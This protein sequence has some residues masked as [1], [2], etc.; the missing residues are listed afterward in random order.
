MRLS[1]FIE[2][3][4]VKR[5]KP[6]RTKP[7]VAAHKS[8]V[9]ILTVWGAAL[10]GLVVMVL[11]QDA[12]DRSG[13]VSGLSS[14]GGIARLA[15]AGGAAV[16]GAALTFMIGAGIKSRV[17]LAKEDNSI[18]S[19]FVDRRVRPIDPASDLGSYSLD[20]P[21]E[22]GGIAG[23]DTNVEGEFAEGWEL[24]PPFITDESSS[25]DNADPENSKP[26]IAEPT[27][28]ELSQRGYDIEAPEELSEAP[29][30]PDEPAFTHRQFRDALIESCEGATCEAAATAD[31]EES[32]ELE[33]ET[34]ASPEAM[35][36]S[37]PDAVPLVAKPR[38]NAEP[39]PIG[40]A[41]GGGA[42]SLTQFSPEAPK[43]SNSAEPS[44]E[45]ASE[46]APSELDTTA[47]APTEELDR[48]LELDLAEFAQLPGRNAVWVEEESIETSAPL[49]LS[50]E[51][52]VQPDAQPETSPAPVPAP[53]P[54]SALEKL[55][56]TPTDKLSLV[57]MVERFAGALHEHQE[58]ERAQ[59][60]RE[61]GGRD[62][63]LAEA[64]KALT[65]FT[66]SGFNR[67]EP[68]ADQAPSTAGLEKTEQELREALAKLQTL[69]GA[70]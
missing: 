21:L 65:L 34:E 23:E 31:A 9:P 61:N 40:R 11:P 42:W 33:S 58:S 53:P 32:G 1:Q 45:A 26:Q 16:L 13:A 7:S 19:T 64:L 29:V 67:A 15:L 52:E 37:E 24:D 63:A 55:R 39:K 46:P 35:A 36:N 57:E 20:A 56:Q 62:A 5:R 49:E 2:R 27:L 44:H 14:L 66:E 25:H 3:K 70:A 68:D 17:A 50:P 12:I 59:T 18:V 22:D 48:P 51:L 6:K 8:F 30:D 10:L 41:G 54:A 4:P 38:K 69:Q 60:E 47:P 28:G 43:Q